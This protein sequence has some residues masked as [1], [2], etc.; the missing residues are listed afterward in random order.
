M[1]EYF[2]PGSEPGALR[3]NPWNVARWGPI[4]WP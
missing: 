3:G 2:I 4:I 1:I